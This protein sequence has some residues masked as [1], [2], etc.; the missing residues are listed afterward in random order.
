VHELW[1]SL[2]VAA[3]EAAASASVAAA[4]A[5]AA[6]GEAG[7]ERDHV[8]A[9]EG[10]GAAGGAGVSA[11]A[12]AAAAARS[13]NPFFS[14]N[15]VVQSLDY[16]RRKRWVLRSD[17]LV[18]ALSA[19]GIVEQERAANATDRMEGGLGEVKQFKVSGEIGI[20][21]SRMVRVLGGSG[22]RTSRVD[23]P[24]GRVASLREDQS[25]VLR[26]MMSQAVESLAK[27]KDLDP[28]LAILQRAHAAGA[29][30]STEDTIQ[31]SG[32]QQVRRMACR[33]MVLLHSVLKW[34][35]PV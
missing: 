26:E 17:K 15:G 3:A 13:A 9:G 8:A 20:V 24:S 27:L 23:I 21:H 2:E 7:K 29:G 6:A 30:Q 31:Q 35:V 11:A 1:D 16:L 18:Y 19:E 33:L 12:A 22:G 34:R 4:A 5:A 28:Y 10:A 32:F 25:K 14:K